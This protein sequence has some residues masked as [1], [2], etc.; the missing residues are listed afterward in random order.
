MKNKKY[1][2]VRTVPKSKKNKT[3]KRK[4]YTASTQIDNRPFLVWFRHFNKMWRGGASAMGPYIN[5]IF[6][7]IVVVIDCRLMLS[8]LAV[9]DI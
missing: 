9:K 1:H 6:V 2:T 5:K 7:E 8:C 3:K 4:M